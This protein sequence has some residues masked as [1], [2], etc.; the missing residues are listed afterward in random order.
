MRVLSL[1]A[2]D[3]PCRP[4]PEIGGHHPE[5][6]RET[7]ASEQPTDIEGYV[8]YCAMVSPCFLLPSAKAERV[9]GHLVEEVFISSSPRAL[10]A[11]FR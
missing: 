6:H 1:E 9:F 5:D 10:A 2:A 7:T 3:R 11:F 8:V 4:S